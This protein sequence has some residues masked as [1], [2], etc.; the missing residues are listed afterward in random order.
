MFVFLAPGRARRSI[1]ALAALLMF[2]G[3]GASQG[4]SSAALPFVLKQIGP[5][6]YAAIDGPEHKSGSNAGFVIGD[7]GVLVVDSFFTTDAARSLVA[8]IRRLTPKPIRYVVNTHYHVDHTGGDQVLRDA[9]AIII[10]HK[11]VRGWVRTNNINLLG[12]RITP[13]LKARIE[14]LPLPDLV[15]DKDLTVWLGSRKIVVKTVLGH[16]GSDLTVFVP[17]AK[18]LFCG[19]L[20]WRKVAPNLIDGSVREW[21]ATDADFEAIPDAAHTHFV[22]GHGDIA[23]VRDVADFRAYLLDLQRLVGEG[24]K[25]GLKGVALTQDVAPKL[26]ARHPDWS[27]SDRAAAFEVRYMDQELSGTKQRPIPQPD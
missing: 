9:G 27:I 18:V 22:P 7:D 26:K 23:E 20:L 8:E 10:A 6:V 5:G 25:S 4:S 12:D 11:N 13:E 2:S 17:D 21:A 1:C 14:A 15:T 19:D 16:T 24:R 3:P